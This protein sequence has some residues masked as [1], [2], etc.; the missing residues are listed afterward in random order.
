MM[1]R[2]EPEGVPPGA[3]VVCM[4]AGTQNPLSFPLLLFLAGAGRVW[5][6]EPG[7]SNDDPDWTSRWG[8]QELTLRVMVGAVRSRYFVRSTAE[9]EEFAELRGLFFGPGLAS[10]LRSD[11]VRVVPAVL[12]EAA[13]PSQ[14]VH[15]VTS[16]SV[17]EHVLDTERCFDALAA[18]V[19]PGGVMFHWIDLSAHDDRDP[20]AFYYDAPPVSTPPGRRDGLNGLRLSDYLAAFEKRGFACRVVERTIVADYDLHRRPL[21]PRYRGYDAEDLRCR[22]AVVVARAPG[23]RVP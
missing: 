16:R 9:L 3:H 7:I 2:L 4:G 20:F 22:R 1:E 12:E 8:L 6:V 13:I 15:L 21:L 17:L 19:A 10:A 18:M 5:V 14:T 11:V 23:E